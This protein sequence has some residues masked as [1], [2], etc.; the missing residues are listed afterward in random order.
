MA[1]KKMVETKFCQI[2]G[3]EFEGIKQAKFCSDECKNK[4]KTDLAAVR[5]DMKRAAAKREKTSGTDWKAIV[6]K[7]KKLN[8]SYGEAVRRGLI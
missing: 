8:M 3:A 6:R 2:C 7:C 1:G 4:R 5:R